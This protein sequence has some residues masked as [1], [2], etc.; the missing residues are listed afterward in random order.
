VPTVG[1]LTAFNVKDRKESNKKSPLGKIYSCFINVEVQM[2][3]SP[4]R[5]IF[6][7]EIKNNF[8]KN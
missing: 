6:L 2:S 5:A 8:S 7:T 4:E 1:N 3:L